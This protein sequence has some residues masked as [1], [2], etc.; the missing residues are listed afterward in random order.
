MKK[1]FSFFKSK[2]K[3]N[4]SL[5][6][7]SFKPVPLRKSTS[8]PS[9]FSLPFKQKQKKD[10]LISFKPV[11]FA[12]Y[13]TKVKQKQKMSW[14]QAKTKY[15]SLNPYADADKDGVPNISD[16]KP[17]NKNEHIV[18]KYGRGTAKDVKD[19]VKKFFDENPEL[20]EEGEQYG[21]KKIFWRFD[22]PKSTSISSRIGSVKPI[23]KADFREDKRGPPTVRIEPGVVKSKDE[24]PKR[25]KEAISFKKELEEK[26]KIKELGPED[27]RYDDD[28]VDRL[29]GYRAAEEAQ[30]EAEME[31]IVSKYDGDDEL[32]ERI[33]NEPDYEREDFYKDDEEKK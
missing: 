1:S 15:P 22:T 24:L 32:K 23:L 26:K 10:K 5:S 29:A 4:K 25:V 16:C 13:A 14:N 9:P 27:F 2:T 7:F 28:A 30:R 3:T 18:I 6:I 20:R 8:I 19:K 33:E 17:F 11:S 21:S 31:T 12:P